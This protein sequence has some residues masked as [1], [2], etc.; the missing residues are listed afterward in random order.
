[1]RIASMTICL[2]AALALA[3]GA[4]VSAAAQ[5]CGPA[6][7]GRSL[8][9]RVLTDLPAAAT[10]D[11]AAAVLRRHGFTLKAREAGRAVATEPLEHRGEAGSQ[12]VTVRVEEKEPGRVMFCA[13][14]NLR[15]SRPLVDL[16]A[17]APDAAF[18]RRLYD[19][20]SDAVAADP[21]S[22]R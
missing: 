3:A 7:S 22:R 21:E 11:S 12:R 13:T 19:E 9:R 20:I 5:D 16:V 2:G 18:P 4:S 1:M 6:G 15:G 8:S 14:W 17:D 10:L